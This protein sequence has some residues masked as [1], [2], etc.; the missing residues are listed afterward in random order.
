MLDMAPPRCSLMTDHEP[1]PATVLVPPGA[2]MSPPWPRYIHEIVSAIGPSPGP[3]CHPVHHLDHIQTQQGAA[4]PP[5]PRVRCSLPLDAQARHSVPWGDTRV[6]SS[7]ISERR[8]TARVPTVVELVEIVHAMT[9][10][11][12]TLGL[13]VEGTAEWYDP[14]TGTSAPSSPH[15]RGRPGPRARGLA[16]PSR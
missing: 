1:G 10:T 14:A 13:H 3:P 9:A 15:G 2:P 16:A 5:E 12:N 8:P 7:A 11:R 6:R 4:N